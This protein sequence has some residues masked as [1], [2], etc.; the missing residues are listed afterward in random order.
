MF[1]SPPTETS[2]DCSDSLAS[3]TLMVP[4]LHNLRVSRSKCMTEIDAGIHVYTLFWDILFGTT[5]KPAQSVGDS[6]PNEKSS[7]PVAGNGLPLC[8]HS[9]LLS[10]QV[11]MLGMQHLLDHFRGLLFGDFLHSVRRNPLTSACKLTH[12]LQC[13]PWAQP[14][15]MNCRKCKRSVCPSSTAF[16]PSSGMRARTGVKRVKLN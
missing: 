16:F 5:C 13:L 3:T 4:L 11:S 6:S 12:C 8:F 2:Y 9:H 10:G 1:R 14:L 15:K 7:K